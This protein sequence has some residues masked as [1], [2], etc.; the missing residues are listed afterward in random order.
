MVRTVPS[1][2]IKAVSFE[3]LSADVLED[4]SAMEVTIPGTRKKTVEIA[5][6]QD[7]RLGSAGPVQLCSTCGCPQTTCQGHPGYI[8]LSEPV[9]SAHFIA[10]LPKI[11]TCLCIRCGTLLV[12]TNTAAKHVGIKKRISVLFEQAKKVRVCPVPECGHAQPLLWVKDMALIRAL[13]SSATPEA[14]LPC[15]TLSYVYDLLFLAGDAAAAA[16]GYDP[17]HAPLS[18]MMFSKFPVPPMLVRPLRSRS[19]DDLTA[20]LRQIVQFS[21]LLPAEHVYTLALRVETVRPLV[22]ADGSAAMSTRH[23]RARQ[24][25]HEA[26]LDPIF[27]LQRAVLAYQDNRYAFKGDLDYGKE[28]NSVRQRFADSKTH[29]GRLRG[30]LMGK[31]GDY[32]ARAVASC[33]A[34]LD[35]DQVGVPIVV[36]ENLTFP[37]T[38]NTFNYQRLLRAVTRGLAW[39]GC[40]HID[41]PST[42]ESFVPMALRG[43]LFGDVVHRHLRTDDW[44]LLNR[45]PSLHRYSIMAYRVVPTRRQTIDMNLCVTPALNADFDGDEVNIFALGSERSRAEAS[46]LLAVSHNVCKDGRLLVGPVQHAVLG[47]F[48][49]TT[50][51]RDRRL[52]HLATTLGFPPSL[53][54]VQLLEQLIPGPAITGP[55]NGSVLRRRVKHWYCQNHFSGGFAR[56]LGHV[57][58]VLENAVQH[59]GVSLSYHDC[60]A[61]PSDASIRE[62]DQWVD[63]AAIAVDEMDALLCLEQARAVIGA[64]VSKTLAHTP[65]S[66]ICVSGAKGK[67]IHVIQNAGIVGQQVIGRG[68]PTKTTAHIHADPASARGFVRSN[69]VSGLNATEYFHHLS[70]ARTGLVATAVSTAET[71]YVYR[72]LF[73]AM[74]DMIVT[75]TYTVCSA[76]NRVIQKHAGFDPDRLEITTW[77]ASILA[78]PL[79][80]AEIACLQKLSTTGCEPCGFPSPGLP[81]PT[82]APPTHDVGPLLEALRQALRQLVKHPGWPP[83]QRVLLAFLTEFRTT[84]LRAAG[85]DTPSQFWEQWPR[86]QRIIEQSFYEPGTPV[87][88]RMAQS[89]SEPLTQAQLDFFHSSGE[90]ETSGVARVKELL[91]LVKKPKEPKMYI[92][93]LPDATL[94][95]LQIVRLRLCDAVDYWE[96]TADRQLVM[97]LNHAAMVER[98]LPPRLIA[99]CISKKLAVP[100]VQYSAVN[101]SIWT[102]SVQLPDSESS[103]DVQALDWYQKHK[104][105]LIAGIPG[106]RSA[107]WKGQTL[108]ANGSNLRAVLLLPGVDVRQTFCNDPHEAMAIGG[109]FFA[110]A[111]L[112]R[113]L[114][115]ACSATSIFQQ[116]PIT[117]IVD[118]MCNSG[119]LVPYTYGG[120]S[121]NLQ[122]SFKAGTFERPVEAFLSSATRGHFDTLSGVSE[123]LVM[124]KLT[125]IGSTGPF[126]VITQKYNRPTYTATAAPMTSMPPPMA[127]PILPKMQAP[128]KGKKRGRGE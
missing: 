110:R 34:S 78:E 9:V 98:K 39:P 25:I 56:H 84:K 66:K 60:L 19:E 117:L 76:L 93:A 85:V 89:F 94:N 22:R 18:S 71:G 28:R 127:M 86:W 62:S 26:S 21:N 96:D 61:T 77:H 13:Y 114:E 116:R 38:V 113:E 20:G 7:P 17:L 29:R 65:L 49:L 32:T 122:C 118:F 124:S 101:A 2:S 121:S 27:D 91:N 6:V 23:V 3:L 14:D 24:P 1:G 59:I 88:L 54:G 82:V 79:H 47:A 120:M 40:T 55:M 37:E 83:G 125:H 8:Q 81:D 30:S 4:M 102:V 106:V 107:Q 45:Q 68:R 57:V 52:G 119:S 123:S 70:A 128:R 74:E 100:V 51:W 92:R 105:T 50:D 104:N 36:L 108:V 90:S 99:Q 16:F 75:H 63:K 43:L 53:T 58:R 64:D 126:K 80:P 112:Q 48:L 33:D 15:V 69:F 109:L 11:L 95:S 115:A 46:E 31:R 73:K 72:K 103:A 5:T 35:P 42:S 41:R 10:S 97:T 12:H 111:T 87:G 67:P 44:V